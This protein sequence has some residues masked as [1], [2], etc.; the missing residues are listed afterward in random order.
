[1][2]KQTAK[3]ENPEQSGF[4][5]LRFLL[6]VPCALRAGTPAFITMILD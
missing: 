5:L 4:P 3:A 2:Q 1:M 6:F